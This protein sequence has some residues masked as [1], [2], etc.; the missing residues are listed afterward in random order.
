[1][2]YGLVRLDDFKRVGGLDG[3]YKFYCADGDLCYKLYQSG[4]QLIP[5]PGCFVVHNN[6]LDV[7]KKVNTDNSGK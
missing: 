7:Q 5:L 1:M 6:V 2:N 4:K 3:R